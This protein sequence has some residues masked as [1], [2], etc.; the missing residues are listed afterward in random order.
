MPVTVSKIAAFVFKNGAMAKQILFYDQGNDGDGDLPGLLPEERK[1]LSAVEPELNATWVS[2]LTACRA[3]LWRRAAGH[4][5]EPSLRSKATRPGTMWTKGEVKMPLLPN[6]AAWCG[7][8]LEVWGT[9]T[10]YQLHAWVWTQPTHRSAA[11]TAIAGV[12]PA[13]WQ[14][15]YGSYLISMKTPEAGDNI[16]ALGEAA[17]EALWSMARPIA[18][19]ITAEQ[20]T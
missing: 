13:P 8:A 1:A 11:A 6:G 17:A 2:L 12:T 5:T 14:N 16:E 15:I 20:R 7:I 4:S 19:A 18:E 9:S 10:T 3:A